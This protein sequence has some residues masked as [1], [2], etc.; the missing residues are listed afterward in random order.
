MSP[1]CLNIISLDFVCLY[2][3]QDTIKLDMNSA[4]LV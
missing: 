2:D 4:L 1:K 3:L